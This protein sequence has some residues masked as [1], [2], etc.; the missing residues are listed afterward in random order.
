MT[1]GAAIHGHN[2]HLWGIPQIMQVGPS[3]WRSNYWWLRISTYV[4]CWPCIFSRGKKTASV[5]QRSIPSTKTSRNATPRSNALQP[6]EISP[7]PRPVTCQR[8]P[9]PLQHPEHFFFSFFLVSKEVVPDFPFEN[10]FWGL[11]F[12]ICCLDINALFKRETPR[13][14]QLLS[15]IANLSPKHQL[16][17]IPAWYP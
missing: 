14:W 5:P 9:W 17:V 11:V 8:S 13:L 16:E 15:S 10:R 12:P 4:L 7:A 6:P 2:H 1:L 3:C